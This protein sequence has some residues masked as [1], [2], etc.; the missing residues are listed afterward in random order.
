MV[1][2]S[3]ITKGPAMT[4]RSLPLS[5]ARSGGRRERLREGQAIEINRGALA[6]LI[7]WLVRRTGGSR[8]IIRSDGLP[9][10]VVLVI[11]AVA[12]TERGSQPAAVCELPA[13]TQQRRSVQRKAGSE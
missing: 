1:R 8:W 3:L 11:E 13:P 12:L 2:F 6:G 9:H 5:R 4:E 7:G 10:G